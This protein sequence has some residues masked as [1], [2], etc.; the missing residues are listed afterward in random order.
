[1]EN[2]I[3]LRIFAAATQFQL[4]YAHCGPLLSV[5]FEPDKIYMAPK[6]GRVY[7]PA[8]SVYG[9]IGL[10]RSKLAIELSQHFEFL[11]G[12]GKPP[13]HFTWHGIR[14]ELDTNWVDAIEWT[15]ADGRLTTN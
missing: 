14:Y 9:S 12:D 6:T 3:L 5:K 7:H 1:M 2:D 13:T 4:T 15:P 10:V 11:A 8:A